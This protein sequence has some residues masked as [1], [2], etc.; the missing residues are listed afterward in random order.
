MT[1][2]P[3]ARL[4]LAKAAEHRFK[5]TYTEGFGPAAMMFCLEF[6]ESVLSLY[7]DKHDVRAPRQV[8]RSLDSHSNSSHLRP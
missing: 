8:R 3:L 4:S 6:M 2:S 7:P 5:A 1:R